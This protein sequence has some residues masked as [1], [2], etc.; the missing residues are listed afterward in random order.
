MTARGHYVNERYYSS[1]DVVV[2]VSAAFGLGWLAEWLA[3]RV[4]GVGGPRSGRLGGPF[5]AVRAAGVA[6]ATM[7]LAAVV[8]V[9]AIPGW[10]GFG[11]WVRD[12]IRTYRSQAAN[13][14]LVLPVLEAELRGAP[15]VHDWPGGTA[16]TDQVLVLPMALWPQASLD[17]DIPLTRIG[18]LVRGDVDVARG[19]PPVGSL[20]LHD[21]SLVRSRPPVPDLEVSEPT[22]IGDVLVV[23]LFADP[24]RGMW[25]L[26]L[27]PAS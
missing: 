2:I 14:A 18:M 4:A 11:T 24:A 22:R 10:A 7:A 9:A 21:R 6:V 13:F 26:R 5:D 12:D 25:L 19:V 20:V 15:G 17:L 16:P 3:S 8:G 23:P 1:M 27:E